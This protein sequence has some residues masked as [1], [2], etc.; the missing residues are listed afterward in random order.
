[1]ATFKKPVHS[2]LDA[3]AGKHFLVAMAVQEKVY[4]QKIYKLMILLKTLL[5]QGLL[6]FTTS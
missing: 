6:K 3:L 5:Y 2:Q 4:G 1:M